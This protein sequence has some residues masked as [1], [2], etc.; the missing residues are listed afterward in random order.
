MQ[1]ADGKPPHKTPIVG[2]W[3][4]LFHNMLEVSAYNAFVIWMEMAP[5]W[6]RGKPFK[7]RLFLEELGKAIVTPFIQHRHESPSSS[8]TPKKKKEEKKKKRYQLCAL[9]DIKTWYY[10]GR[11]SMDEL[12]NMPSSKQAFTHTH[13][14][15]EILFVAQEV[16]QIVLLSQGQQFKTLN[17]KLLLTGVICV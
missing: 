13:G 8:L 3:H 11:I 1:P 16:E 7:R 4:I 9:R 6:K 15:I 5:A 2:Y 14:C 17:P 10:I 12:A